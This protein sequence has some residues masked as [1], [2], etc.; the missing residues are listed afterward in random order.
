M[1]DI[2]LSGIAQGAQAEIAAMSQ[3]ALT[4]IIGLGLIAYA[5]LLSWWRL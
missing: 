4:A 3:A 5:L 1:L 2:F